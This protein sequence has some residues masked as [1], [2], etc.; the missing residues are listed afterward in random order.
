MEKPY[1]EYEWENV[2]VRKFSL[3]VEY[4]DLK[5]HMDSEDREIFVVFSAGWHLQLENKLPVLLKT[6][7]RIFIPKFKWHR[8][9]KGLSTLTVVVKKF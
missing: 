8:L 6:G 7:D 1:V 5:W 9:C 3:D 2:S 4:F